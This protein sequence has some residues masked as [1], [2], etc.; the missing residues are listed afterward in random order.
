MK[1]SI[2]SSV[3]NWKIVRVKQN[4]TGMNYLKEMSREFKAGK[5]L[6]NSGFAS[7]SIDYL[8]NKER[9][10]PKKIGEIYHLQLAR[11]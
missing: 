3:K 2:N 4:I 10:T 1:K 8:W 11:I 7:K 5:M 9:K 6:K